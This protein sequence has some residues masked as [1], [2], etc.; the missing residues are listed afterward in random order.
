[1]QKLITRYSGRSLFKLV[2]FRLLTQ[3]TW[4]TM[5]WRTFRIYV[6]YMGGLSN[7]TVGT[8]F[9]KFYKYLYFTQVPMSCIITYLTRARYAPSSYFHLCKCVIEYFRILINLSF[10]YFKK[11]TFWI[12]C[13][14]CVLFFN[15]KL[16]KT[17]MFLS[18][19][20]VPT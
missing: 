17:N 11:S 20:V 9:T 12:K 14:R 16:R 19:Y 18:R 6:R 4:F 2:Q 8:F 1:M 5:K 7:F 10:Y 3:R 13:A 15:N